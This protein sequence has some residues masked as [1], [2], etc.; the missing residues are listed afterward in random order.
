MPRLVDWA[1][2]CSIYLYPNED[3][4]DR[5][6]QVGGS[7]FLFRIPTD[8][9]YASFVYAVSNW[10]VVKDAPVVRFNTSDGK[11]DVLPLTLN[12]WHRHQDGETDLAVAPVKLPPT[13]TTLI[14][15]PEHLLTR[16]GIAQ[17]NVGLGEDLFVVGRFVDHDGKERNQPTARF[18]AIAQ[19]PGDLIRTEVG[20][21]DAFL[22]DIRS[23]SGYS[24]SPVFALLPRHRDTTLSMKERLGRPIGGIGGKERILLIGVDCGHMLFPDPGGVFAEVRDK[25]GNKKLRSTQF[26]VNVNSGMAIVVGAWKLDELLNRPELKAMRDQENQ[27]RKNAAFHTKLDSATRPRLQKTLAPEEQDRIDI[28]IPTKGEVMDVFKKATRKRQKKQ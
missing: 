22:A 28:R 21:Q 2:D 25:Q 18:G 27:Q 5:G 20:L 14:V 15:G 1:L 6:E 24:G 8:D 10:H 16:D 17:F 12:N 11:C 7:G 13:N 19:M 23:V 26:R 4:A 3:D 9:T